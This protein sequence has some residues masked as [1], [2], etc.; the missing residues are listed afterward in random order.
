MGIGEPGGYRRGM[1]LPPLTAGT[2]YL[3]ATPIGN[4]EDITLAGVADVE[5]VRRGGG[6]GHAADGAVA[7]A[8][9][10]FAGRW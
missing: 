3:V 6:G 10:D 5:G 9:R 2:L 8:L 1:D 4:L 7:E